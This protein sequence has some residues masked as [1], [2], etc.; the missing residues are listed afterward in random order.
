MYT[1]KWCDWEDIIN[2]AFVE[3]LENKDRYLILYGGRGSAKSD[4]TAKKLIYRC[5]TENYFRYLLIRNTYSS[6]KDSSYQ[7]IKDIIY[8]LGLEDLFEFKLQPLEIHC[9]NGNSFLARGCDDTTRL[10]S[11]KDATGA[12][13][14][15]DIPNESDFITITTSIRT[16]KA[17]YL[18]EIFSIN[19]EVEGHYEDHWF[20]QRFFKGKLDKTFRDKTTIQINQNTSVDL[21]YS[22]MHSDYT[23]NRW[24]PNEFI[25]F[26]ENLK[27]SNP[28]YYTIYCKGEWGNRQSGGLFYKLFNRA[29]SVES[30]ISY[31]SN[32]ALHISFD[33]NVN[34]YMSLTIWQIHGKVAMCIDEITTVSPDN[35]TMGICREFVRKYNSHASGLFIYGDPAGKHQDT[36]TEAGHNDYLIILQEL[37]KFK[38]VLRVANVA[39]SIVTR[40]NFINTIFHNGFSDVNVLISDKCKVLI[41]DLLF[42][43]ES[44]DGTKHKEKTK[45]KESGVSHEKYGHLSD[46]MDYFICEAF[47][48]EY[49][50][51]Q[52]GSDPTI[53]TFGKNSFNSRVKY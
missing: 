40:G 36:R 38:P 35:T 9:K 16:Q 46:T 51:Y 13:Y 48:N 29:K 6:I 27:I 2:K 53:S 14:E 34:P 3:Y 44:S 26:L 23:Y 11:I 20:W 42:T 43:K 5:L 21:T 50:A 47:I 22:V 52:F 10:K 18:Q 25:A 4:F 7:T 19:P 33:F 15:E 28:Y 31:N 37:Q 12:W 45:D 41:N 1:I 17:D 49:R 39:P 8:D 30:T 24:I 32:A